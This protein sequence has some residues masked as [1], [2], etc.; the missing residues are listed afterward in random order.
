[1]DHCDD[2]FQ[3]TLQQAEAP[4]PRSILRK[5]RGETALNEYE[6]ILCHHDDDVRVAGGH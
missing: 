6:E 1:M 2:P 5:L 3:K 4:E